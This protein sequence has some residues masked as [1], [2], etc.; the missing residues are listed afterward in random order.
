MFKFLVT[1]TQA[2]LMREA[3]IRTFHR[4]PCCTETY[5][6]VY[7]ELESAGVL[8]ITNLESSRHQID[9]FDISFEVFA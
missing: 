1:N 3:S 5:V 9:R 2:R 8:N 4:V 6:N 7:H